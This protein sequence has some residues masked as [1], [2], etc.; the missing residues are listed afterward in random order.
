MRAD[1]V[2]SGIEPLPPCDATRTVA[3]TVISF[4]WARGL[5]TDHTR[6]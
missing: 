3:V 2:E 5:D 4:R 1:T 6:L